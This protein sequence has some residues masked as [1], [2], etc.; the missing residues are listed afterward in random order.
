MDFGIGAAG[1]FQIAESDLGV[2]HDRA[3]GHASLLELDFRCDFVVFEKR[4][5]TDRDASRPFPPCLDQAGGIR[6]FLF[7]KDIR[8]RPGIQTCLLRLYQRFSVHYRFSNVLP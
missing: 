6:Q 4:R 3:V 8:P 2:Q 5:G 1:F 7:R